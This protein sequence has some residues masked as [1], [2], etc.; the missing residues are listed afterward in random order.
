MIEPERLIASI[1]SEFKY[2]FTL[3]GYT[4]Q[5][6]IQSFRVEGTSNALNRFEHPFSLVKV[7]SWFSEFWLFLEIRFI[8][9]EIK[10]GRKTVPQLH[11]SISVSVFQGKDSDEI[12]YQLF[13][14]EWDDFNNSKE[15]HSQ[16]HWHITSNQALEK[17]FTDYAKDLDQDG[18]ISLLENEKEKVLDVTK[19]HFA[20]NGNWQN[21]QTNIH[22]IDD[23]KKIVNWFQ[24]LLQ[25]IKTELEYVN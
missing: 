15:I 13:R 6:N 12:K 5:H 3:K 20:M 16:P 1:N 24:G 9:N 19:I 14:A 2:L 8:K 17:S 4:T 22:G 7:F 25:H 18:F 11:T 21:G 23:E 10:K